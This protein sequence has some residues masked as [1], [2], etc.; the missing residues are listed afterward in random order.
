[1]YRPVSVK[2]CGLT[3]ESDV[4]LALELGADF[5]GFI[6]YPKSQRGLSF[7]RAVELASRVPE[8]K[9]VL[10]DVETGTDDLEHR[11]DAGF[12]YFQI[13]AGLD[14]GL[15]SLA[16]WSGLVGR[17]HL[18]L[19]PRLKPGDAFPEMVFEFADT[20]L[21]DTYHKDQVGGTGETGDWSG[22]AKLKQT[23]SQ[24][25]WVLAGGLK[26]DNVLGAIAASGADWVDV[27]SGVESEPGIKNPEKLRELF[28]VL[29]PS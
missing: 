13:H 17:E 16:A 3:R 25:S 24:T 11:R 8:G 10:V 7:E 29:K 23:Y 26:P 19:A 21:L 4:D 12:D 28:G 18:W 5:C 22:F 27:S 6:V 15:A 20:V 14:V 9:R 2:V 1:M